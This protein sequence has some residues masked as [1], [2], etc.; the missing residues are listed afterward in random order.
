MRREPKA[1]ISIT[2]KPKGKNSKSEKPI[3]IV[4]TSAWS[5]LKADEQIK[6][7]MISNAVLTDLCA[8]LMKKG[9]ANVKR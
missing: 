9:E 6:C 3:S 8:E 1:Q 7:L 2:W 5:D 4:V